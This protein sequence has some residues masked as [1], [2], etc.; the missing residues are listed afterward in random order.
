MS[1]F[2]RI[3]KNIK[4]CY[5]LWVSIYRHLIKFNYLDMFQNGKSKR[6]KYQHRN[7]QIRITFAT[8]LVK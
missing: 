5:N 2:P 7:T 3:D 8:K 1:L 4:S 6:V